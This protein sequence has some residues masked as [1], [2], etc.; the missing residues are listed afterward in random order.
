MIECWDCPVT[1]GEGGEW[2]RVTRQ[3]AKGNTRTS[4]SESAVKAVKVF[5]STGEKTT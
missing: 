2:T 1:E 3:R 5:T 4:T